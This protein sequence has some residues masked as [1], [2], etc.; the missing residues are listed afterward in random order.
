V[1]ATLAQL[2]PGLWGALTK[3]G[4]PVRNFFLMS[5]RIACTPGFNPSSHQML[6]QLNSTI[7]A[8]ILLAGSGTL[9]DAEEG[10]TPS[11]L[12]SYFVDNGQD[13]LLLA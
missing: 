11:Y 2:E 13:G 7:I 1:L 6:N 10:T 12:F 4:I 8:T 3:N 9:S 5:G